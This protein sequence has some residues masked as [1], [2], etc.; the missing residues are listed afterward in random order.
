[1]T[2]SLSAIHFRKIDLEKIPF[3]SSR[4][5]D[6]S[7]LRQR[8]FRRKIENKSRT[9]NAMKNNKITSISLAGLVSLLMVATGTKGADATGDRN[10]IGRG[11]TLTG[12]FAT[13]SGGET[14][15]ATTNYATVAGG[16]LNQSTN[17]ASFVGS[18]SENIAGGTN[19]MVGGG[20]QNVASSHYSAIVGGSDNAV[21][22]SGLYQCIGGGAGNTLNAGSFGQTIAGGYINTISG[23]GGQSTIGGGYNNLVDGADVGT[24]SGGANNS[25]TAGGGSIGGGSINSVT[26]F[27]GTIPGGAGASASH[28][29]QL[30]YGAGYFAAGGDAQTSLYVA[31]RTT[32]SA[33]ATELFLGGDEIT[34]TRMTIPSG[35]TWIFEI[36]VVARSTNLSPNKSAGYTAKGIIDNIGGTTSFVAA[37]VTVVGEDDMNWDLQLVADD[38]NDA[39]V[40]KGVGVA[41][42]TIRWV[43]SV[44]TTEVSQ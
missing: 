24:I 3:L 43:A 14:N 16:F 18:G 21:I 5:R 10:N 23:V 28:Y 25:V 41:N 30:A 15:K 7:L 11:H 26:A 9:G 6:V 8:Q 1:M 32:T 22:G 2:V 44:R 42:T 17:Y 35:S 20:Y 12:T 34:G 38:T 39:L 27:Q 4:S 36:Q 29:G 33:T 13:I 31:R 37:S 19:S 40:I